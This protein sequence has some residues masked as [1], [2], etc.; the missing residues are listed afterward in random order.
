MSGYEIKDPSGL[1]RAAKSAGD[2]SGHVLDA[3]RKTG[4]A[5]QPAVAACGFGWQIGSALDK[6]TSSWQTSLAKLADQTDGYRDALARSAR[7]YRRAEQ[8]AD[9]AVTEL[10]S[11]LPAPASQDV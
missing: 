11:K 7:D 8:N 2:V 10:W 3:G 5:S 6:T 4:A 9:G 1:D